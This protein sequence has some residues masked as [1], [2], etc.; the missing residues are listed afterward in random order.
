ML[1]QVGSYHRRNGGEA[2]YL[3]KNS[4]NIIL[5]KVNRFN[6]KLSRLKHQ[7]FII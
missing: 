6:F 1:G 5:R 3:G 7:I 2:D 4:G